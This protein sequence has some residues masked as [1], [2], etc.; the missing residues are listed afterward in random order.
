MSA[1]AHAPFASPRVARAMRPVAFDGLFG[2]V[3]TPVGPSAGTGV[4]IV[5]PFGRDARCAHMPMR[6]FADELAASGF[7]TLRY[8]HRGTGDSLDLP[9]DEGDALPDWLAGVQAA[10]VELR[11][12]TGVRRVVLCGLRLGASLAAVA[13]A[14]A[15]G[16]I[17]LA[18]VLNGRSWLR[19]LRFASGVVSDPS[20]QHM[21]GEALDCDGVCLSAA[22]VAALDRM[23]LSQS[24]PASVPVLIAAQN[25]L[26]LDY[27]NDR[28]A[29]GEAAQTIEFP[30]FK[31][32]FLEP[33]SNLP[34]NELFDEA[35]QWLSRT[36]A[37]LADRAPLAVFNGVPLARLQPPAAI[38]RAVEFGAGLQGVLCEPRGGLR[39]DYVVM[40]CNTGGD[41][42]AGA[43]GFAT[44]TA[45]R[46]AAGGV[47][48]LRFDFGGIGDSPMPGAEVRCHVFETDRD[49]DIDAAVAFCAEQGF[50]TI[51]VIGVCAGAYHAFH[52]AWRHR[53]V[54]GV[55]AVS[56]VKLV[57][58]PGDSLIF[59]GMLNPQAVKGYL[60]A[61][62]DIETWKRAVRGQLQIRPLALAIADRLKNGII[63]LVARLNRSAPLSQMRAFAGRGGRACVVM[64]LKDGSFDEVSVHFGVSEAMRRKALNTETVVIPDLDHGLTTQVSRDLAIETLLRWLDLGAA[65]KSVQPAAI[66]SP[67]VGRADL[68]KPDWAFRGK[69][70]QPGRG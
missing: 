58:R 44:Q 48:S 27:A 49:A 19:R 35:R 3:H 46:L 70:S 60:D 42:R 57:W 5:S 24:E 1:N 22:T 39:E 68:W 45:R 10:M 30:G 61:L 62:L 6:I 26:V 12:R 37:H 14:G 67:S 28:V 59:N 34:P 40:F 63:G 29:R 54:R 38:E 11:A 4:V 7:P 65:Q 33:H 50:R 47:A 32:L 15:D 13:G 9:D 51:V 36:Y 21:D 31:S 52:A 66:T 53:E 55:F 17:L 64:G 23:D 69:A 56:P 41:P 43:G 20:R 8:D 25:K 18:P 16:L 2:Y